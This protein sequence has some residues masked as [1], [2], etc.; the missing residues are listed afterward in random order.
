[1]DQVPHFC[2]G[3][4]CLFTHKGPSC[5]YKNL[6]AKC[7]S[8][9]PAEEK[10][11]IKLSWIPWDF[12]SKEV[13][14]R[15]LVENVKNAWAVSQKPLCS[16]LEGEFILLRQKSSLLL[17]CHGLS[18]FQNPTF[19]GWILNHCWVENLTDIHLCNGGRVTSILG[20]KRHLFEK[21]SRVFTWKWPIFQMN[22]V[23]HTRI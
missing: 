20:E 16:M 4:A 8:K 7:F 23:F 13:P 9:K 22:K 12:C 2:D 11:V 18:H 10:I 14:T 3:K 1:M 21:E 6:S 15:R 19:H 5:C 17:S